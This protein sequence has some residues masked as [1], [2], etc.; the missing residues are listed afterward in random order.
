MAVDNLFEIALEVSVK[1]HG[2]AML[3]SETKRL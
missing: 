2:R 1:R 3:A